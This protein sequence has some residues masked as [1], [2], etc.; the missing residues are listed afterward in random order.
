[1]NDL[2]IPSAITAELE[3]FGVPI[4]TRRDG[5]QVYI[6]QMEDG[7]ITSALAILLPWKTRI[8]KTG[9]KDLTRQLKQTIDMLRR[10]QRRRVKR[11]TQVKRK[12]FPRS[13]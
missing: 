4:W 1:M 8:N 2:I 12:A 7:H 13:R 6:D 10:E 9:D 3:R 11:I 5:T